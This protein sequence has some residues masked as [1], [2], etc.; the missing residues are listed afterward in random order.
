MKFV[1]N[2]PRLGKHLKQW[3]KDRELFVGKFYFWRAGSMEQRS[4]SGLVRS[5]ITQLS[6]AFP[7]L[8][9]DSI[10]RFSGLL[11]SWTDKKLYEALRNLI[12]QHKSRLKVCIFIDG[13]DELEGD[14]EGLFQ[15]FEDLVQLDS[16]KVCVSSRPEPALISKFSSC[17]KLRLQDFNWRD[18]QR[19]TQAE[20][21]RS[22]YFRR[23]RDEEVERTQ[24]Q[25]RTGCDDGIEKRDGP[26]KRPLK[27][28]K[29]VRDICVKSEGVFLWS[30]LAVS[31][32]K[33]GLTNRDTLETLFRRLENLDGSLSGLF[34]Q[35][36]A[37]IDEVYRVESAT[38]LKIMML[39]ARMGFGN[40]ALLQIAAV[41]EPDLVASLKRFAT[42]D[43]A[44]EKCLSDLLQAF[45]DLRI[46]LVG[47]TAGL[48]TIT[49]TLVPS[50]SSTKSDL[51]HSLDNILGSN[52]TIRFVHRSVLD[53]LSENECARNFLA[54]CTMPDE[55]CYSLLGTATITCFSVSFHICNELDDYISMKNP[56]RYLR[57]ILH[58]LRF[59][60]DREFH[61]LDFRSLLNQLEIILADCIMRSN[62]F[63]MPIIH[64]VTNESIDYLIRLAWSACQNGLQLSIAVKCWLSLRYEER[65]VFEETWKGYR[66]KASI[67]ATF[68]LGAAV[69]TFV[70][71]A[72]SRGTDFI[73]RALEHGADPNAKRCINKWGTICFYSG[74]ELFLRH[75]VPSQP[76]LENTEPTSF[77]EPLRYFLSHGADK[78]QDFNVDVH[79]CTNNS[80]RWIVMLRVRSYKYLEQYTRVAPVDKALLD[81]NYAPCME[82]SK[83]PDP[84]ENGA[85]LHALAECTEKYV[86]RVL[87]IDKFRSSSL[88][89]EPASEKE[90]AA[91]T[92]A[93]AESRK[94]FRKDPVV[95]C[96]RDIFQARSAVSANTDPSR[97]T[98]E[99]AESFSHEDSQQDE[100]DDKA[101]NEDKGNVKEKDQ[102]R[103]E[104]GNEYLTKPRIIETWRPRTLE[105]LVEETQEICVDRGFI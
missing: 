12:Q 53:F 64:D 104:E 22:I 48:T 74:W 31:D 7:G 10:A 73:I 42:E 33:K 66:G 89:E 1:V 85:A 54:G 96:L 92:R 32:I 62:P 3:A 61:S 98:T 63:N 102:N 105:G 103:D 93:L 58:I 44:P 24:Y 41:Q 80:D 45:E 21:S 13:L 47:K 50:A 67:L 30:A 28:S 16:V 17:P 68:L 70:G 8:F 60:P 9:Q 4:V 38:T 26:P 15:P 82:K 34:M 5:M 23:L 11:R 69:H 77:A 83:P 78:E 46:H 51:I 59:C 39:N 88:F 79:I 37:R 100:D 14:L 87:S 95:D 49:G 6:L 90:S 94:T 99:M 55:S 75:Y 65:Q 27:H 35:F 19:F 97:M 91:I 76:L 43:T 81:E 72:G 20:L 2:D 56:W 36:I 25:G 84:T 40:L 86:E 57:K 18:I 29:L 71:G 52:C 101:T